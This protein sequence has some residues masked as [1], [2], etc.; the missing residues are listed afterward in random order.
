MSKQLK[1]IYSLSYTLR[2]PISFNVIALQED[3]LKGQRVEKFVVEVRP[4]KRMRGGQWQKVLLSVINVCCVFLLV[5]QSKFVY[6]FLRLGDKRTSLSLA[7]IK[8]NSLC[9]FTPQLGTFHPF[10]VPKIKLRVKG[11]LNPSTRSFFITNSLNAYIA[12]IR[13]AFLTSR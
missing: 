7:F 12:I 11:F 9:S 1:D 8:T 5:R 13:K 4:S 6:V 10:E 3:I 2:Q